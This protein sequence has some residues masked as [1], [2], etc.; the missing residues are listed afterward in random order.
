MVD[1]I[2][3]IRG[4]DKIIPRMSLNPKEIIK[5]I[6]FGTFSLTER[7]N[8]IN[9]L[10]NA[11]YKVGVI[12]APIILVDGYKKL[13]K[14]LF[15]TLNNNLTK[16]AKKNIF[17]EMIFMTYSY[18]HNAINNEDYKNIKYEIYKKDMMTGRGKGKY[19]YKTTIKDNAKLFMLDFKKKYFPK[20]NLIYII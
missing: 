10:Y 19:M 18:V 13:Y 14:E 17:F 16:E 2:L 1:S 15:I 20:N 5:H 3:N 12:I 9:K 4:K 7:I 6:E 11:G 8:A